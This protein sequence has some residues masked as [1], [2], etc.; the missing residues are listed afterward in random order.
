[1]EEGYEQSTSALGTLCAI[2]RNYP[3]SVGILRELLQNSDDAG[4]S[5]QVRESIDDPS[6]LKLLFLTH[7]T[8]DIR[9]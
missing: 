9:P 2:I 4:A 6:T 8:P 7:F 5:K 1:M 3:F